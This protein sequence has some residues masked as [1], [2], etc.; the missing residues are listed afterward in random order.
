MSRVKIE[1]FQN[2]YNTMLF[3][4]N[5]YLGRLSDDQL[6]QR[7]RPGGNHGVWILGHLIASDDDLSMYL[8]RGP[9][10]F[11]EY[12]EQFRRESPAESL[13][14][15]PD[16]ALL[17][18]QW[19]AVCDKNAA[20]YSELTDAELDAP[21]AMLNG[22]IEEDYFKTKEGVLLNWIMHQQYHVGQL[23]LLVAGAKVEAE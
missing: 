10:L 9:V 13:D 11:P 20:I 22:P 8:G 6:R 1:A 18:Q 14:G 17:K 21:H 4:V 2:V 12:Q 23:G 5:H 3:W 19:Q 16:I 15:Y 7:V